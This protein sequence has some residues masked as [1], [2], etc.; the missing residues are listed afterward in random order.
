LFRVK[1]REILDTEKSVSK[2][3]W[4]YVFP[5]VKIPIFI[6][7]FDDY[8]MNGNNKKFG[9]FFKNNITYIQDMRE[10]YIRIKDFSDMS[11]IK[12]IFN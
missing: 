6:E 12:Q 2:M 8:I 1:L 5:D 9:D 4:E 10:K 11:K 3:A 7:L